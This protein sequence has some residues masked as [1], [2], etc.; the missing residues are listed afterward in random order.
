MRLP[1]PVPIIF[2]LEDGKRTVSETSSFLE[3]RQ[4]VIT[5]ENA[6]SLIPHYSQYIEKTL[7]STVANLLTL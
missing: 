6:L 2:L 5:K 4:W 7:Q 3:H 1:F